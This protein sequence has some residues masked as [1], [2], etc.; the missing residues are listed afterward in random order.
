MGAPITTQEKSGERS[1]S[2]VARNRVVESV[3]VLQVSG[4]NP[5]AV[6]GGVGVFEMHGWWSGG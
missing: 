4:G 5:T 2:V 1:V 6:D 3:R